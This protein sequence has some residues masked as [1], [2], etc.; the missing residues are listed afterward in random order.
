MQLLGRYP[1]SLRQMGQQQLAI[2]SKPK[3]YYPSSFRHC[4]IASK[5][6][7]HGNKESQ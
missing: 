4:Q 6:K 3:N 2:K 7:D 5:M 1:S